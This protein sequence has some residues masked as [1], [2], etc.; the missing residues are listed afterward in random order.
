MKTS[1]V[2]ERQVP[3]FVRADYPTFVE[4]LKL[5][6]KWYEEYSLGD[7]EDLLD[8]DQTI[9]EFVKYFRKELDIY[10]ITSNL[11]N[12]LY[13]K[14]IKELYQLKGSF[15]GIEFLLR[16]TRNKS[17]DI[18]IP[19][20]YV[21]KPSD[22]KWHQDFSINVSVTTGNVD[23]LLD[24]QIIFTDTDG[25]QYKTFVSNI[26]KRINST[27]VELFVNRFLVNKKLVSFSNILGTISG[28]CLKSISKITVVDAG[29]DFKLG[30]IVEIPSTS[31][32]N[33]FAKVK[34]IDENNGVKILEIVKFGVGYESDFSYSIP[35]SSA[36]LNCI[37]GT[38]CLYPGYYK[39]SDNI[40][41][42]TAFIQD[43]RYYQA[44]SYVTILE[45]SI[46]KYAQLLRKTMHPAGTKH[47]G[48][49]KLNYDYQ[50]SQQFE[51]NLNI[52]SKKD[53]IRDYVDI[54]DGIRFAIDSVF[55]T[56]S[57]T[58]TDALTRAAEYIRSV[59]DATSILD[60]LFVAFK[61]T[62]PEDSI[63][64]TDLLELIKIQILD[65][66]DVA[67]II[68]SISLTVN[69]SLSDSATTGFDSET[70]G[71]Y[72]SPYY[73]D[74]IYWIPGYIEDEYIFTN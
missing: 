19:W 73:V 22:G 7:I 60:S 37:I 44:F 6:Y 21:F 46:D 27:I 9:D 54:L 32:I 1:L 45:E 3:E 63:S 4:F 51:T 13:L 26:N 38:T 39:T 59:E 17:S 61:V 56:Q 42:D 16:L 20:D 12:R 62:I 10:G 2:V 70:S 68:D 74:P 53:V 33:T 52:I 18:V 36:K 72:K 48:I 23:N 55:G 29:A 8:I 25:K 40:I 5:Y 43:S 11:D 24:K 65:N 30:Q 31:G 15:E 66:V 35:E 34:Q 47:F 58:I 69:K 71:I 41:G 67:T 14:R 57:V 64:A 49:Y 50:F 28:T